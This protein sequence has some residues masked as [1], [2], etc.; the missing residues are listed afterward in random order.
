[1]N[2]DERLH[3][4]VMRYAEAEIQ[5]ILLG[6]GATLFR[7][8]QLMAMLSGYVH[9]NIISQSE[10]DEIRG[11]ARVAFDNCLFH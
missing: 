11:D 1:M 2:N 9:C 5:A 7:Y 8:D 4:K 3:H 6:H 10:A